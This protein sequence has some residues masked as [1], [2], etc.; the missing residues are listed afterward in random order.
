MKA[1]EIIQLVNAG[2]TKSEIM[3]LAGAGKEGQ[4]PDT[5]KGG[6]DKKKPK[7]NAPKEG[8]GEDPAQKVMQDMIKGLNESIAG[9]QKTIQKANI[10]GA[11][12]DGKPRS[13]DEQADEAI[14]ELLK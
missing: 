7:P 1:E 2:F 6:E 3:Q 9:L 14:F 8:Q 5:P 13:I 11:Y 12:E 4:E 10:K